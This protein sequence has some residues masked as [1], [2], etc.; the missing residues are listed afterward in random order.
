MIYIYYK[1]VSGL[2]FFS[3]SQL[4]GQGLPLT[5]RVDR[6]QVMFPVVKPHYWYPGLLIVGGASHEHKNRYQW[7]GLREN[8]QE[9]IEFPINYGAFL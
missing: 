9:T 6:T 5:T 8:L 7:I 4:S 2:V 1:W 3:L